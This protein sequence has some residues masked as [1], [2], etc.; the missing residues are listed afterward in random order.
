MLQELLFHNIVSDIFSLEFPLGN[1]VP[2]GRLICVVL[3]MVLLVEMIALC[4]RVE[5]IAL[6]DCVRQ[7][8]ITV[9]FDVQKSHV[10]KYCKKPGHTIDKCYKLY[11]YPHNFKFTKGSGSRKTAAHVEVNSADPPG[12]VVS[13]MGSKS[14]KSSDSGAV[15]M[16]PGLTQGPFSQLMILLQHSLVFA[17]SSSTPS[18]MASANFAGKLLSKSSLLKSIQWNCSVYQNSSAIH[19]PFLKM[20]LVLG[21]LDHNLYKLL[22]PPIASNSATSI[23]SCI[24]NSSFISPLCALPKTN[25]IEKA[26]TSVNVVD[27]DER[28]VPTDSHLDTSYGSH[29]FDLLKALIAMTETQFQLKVQTVRSDNALELGSSTVGSKF[30]FEKGILHQI[31]H[32]P[33]QNGVVEMKHKHLLEL[34]EPF[35]SNL[36]SPLDSGEIQLSTSSHDCFS[37][38]QPE[39]THPFPNPG[40]FLASTLPEYIFL[41]SPGSSPSSDLPSSSHPKSAIPPCNSESVLVSSPQPESALPPYNIES[42]FPPLRRSSRPHNTPTYLQNYICTLPSTCSGS[43]NS[44]ITTVFS[45]PHVFEPNSYSQAATVPAWQKAMRKEFEELEANGTWNID[46]LTKGKKPIGCK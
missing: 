33:Q 15:S 35:F 24:D 9:N 29:A 37:P 5:V 45:E 16:V 40:I 12:S 36:A 42:D 22:L 39:A 34:P 46:E 41:S 13:K 10:C 44:S 23:S 8:A 17:D 6:C 25:K 18:L 20:P 11:S 43:A 1:Q 3:V 21:K 30:I 14:V 32:T 19:A 27:Y 2:L 4:D 31:T 7:V 38:I 26:I 28:H